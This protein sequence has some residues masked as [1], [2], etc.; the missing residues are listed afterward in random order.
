MSALDAVPPHTE[1]V[2]FARLAGG[3]LDMVLTE[4][5]REWLERLDWDIAEIAK[6]V[7]DTRF[8]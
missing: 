5:R 6:S 2:P 8:G 3:A 4:Q 7:Y 1:I